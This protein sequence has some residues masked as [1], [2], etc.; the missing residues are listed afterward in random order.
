MKAKPN[1]LLA[2]AD[3]DLLEAADYYL[4]AGGEPVALN[5]F[6]TLDRCLSHLAR[7]PGSGSERLAYELHL[8]GLRSWPMG[9]FPYVILYMESEHQLDVLRVLN[10]KRDLPS[11]LE[12]LHSEQPD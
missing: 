8:P 7:F 5:F 11:W 6:K 10:G 9:R 12:D 1:R 4:D 2:R 3:Q